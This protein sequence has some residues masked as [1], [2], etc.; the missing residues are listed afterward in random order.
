MCLAKEEKSTLSW[1]SGKQFA[2]KICYSFPETSNHQL[3]LVTWKKNWTFVDKGLIDYFL[4]SRKW[5]SKIFEHVCNS[6]VHVDSYYGHIFYNKQGSLFHI[7]HHKYDGILINYNWFCSKSN[8]GDIFWLWNTVIN[9]RGLQ[10]MFN[11]S[12]SLMAV[13]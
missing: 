6:E 2:S 11:R 8:M 1:F 12:R 3:H 13:I 7:L 5:S 4:P 9:Y 10:N